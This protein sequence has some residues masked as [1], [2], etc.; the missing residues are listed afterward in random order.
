MNKL[1]YTLAASLLV[2]V[3][4]CGR[5]PGLVVVPDIPEQISMDVRPLWAMQLGDV[6]QPLRRQGWSRDLQPAWQ[7]QRLLLAHNEH[8]QY[9]DL[10]DARRPRVIWQ[11]VTDTLSAGP[12]LS[13]E[14]FAVVTDKAQLQLR[15]LGDASLIWQQPLSARANALPA[16]NDQ[17]VVS[18]NQDGTIQTFRR[19]DG[20]LVWQFQTRVPELSLLGTARPVMA[21]DQVIIATPGGRVLSMSLASGQVNWEYRIAVSSGRTGFDRLV[22]ADATPLVVGDTVYVSALNGQLV[23]IDLSTGRVRSVL[24]FDSLVA[25]LVLDDRLIVISPEGHIRALTPSGQELW[26]QDQWRLRRYTAPVLWGDY[27]LVTDAF[28]GMI[29]LNPEDGQLHHAQSVHGIGYVQSPVVVGQDIFLQSASGRI[30][31][32]R[33]R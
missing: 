5:G 29:V 26:R 4:A 12:S 1:T 8:L 14:Q 11:H 28:G 25:P 10:S 15:D 23:Q 20:S 13:G 21:G 7:S 3:A 9:L 27:I 16:L 17:Y 31:A 33:L 24:E 32:L 6:Q 2:L 22:D 30:T 19:Q 18:Y